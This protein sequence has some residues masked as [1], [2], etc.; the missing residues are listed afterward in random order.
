MKTRRFAIDQHGKRIYIGSS[1]KY[2]N[3]IFLVEDMQ[4]LS[5]SKDQYLTLTDKKNKNKK[6]DFVSSSDVTI[7]Y[8]TI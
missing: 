2:N 6:I 8:K 7:K 1:V 4:Y 3:K 5:W